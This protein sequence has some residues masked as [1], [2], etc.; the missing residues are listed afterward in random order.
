M[1]SLRNFPHQFSIIHLLCI[2]TV[3]GFFLSFNVFWYSPHPSVSLVP[4]LIHSIQPLL[5][6]SS[7]GLSLSSLLEFRGFLAQGRK[8]FSSITKTLITSVLNPP[9]PPFSSS[10][11]LPSSWTLPAHEQPFSSYPTL[12]LLPQLL[13]SSFLPPPHPGIISLVWQLLSWKTAVMASA[14]HTAGCKWKKVEGW[15][16]G[17]QG[18]SIWKTWAPLSAPYPT[19]STV[20]EACSSSTNTGLVVVGVGCA[21]WLPGCGGWGCWWGCGGGGWRFKQM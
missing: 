11:P 9:L 10:A 1:I 18:S 13:Q 8:T 5:H 2:L 16:W 7:Q 3:L 20:S 17:G 21:E 15:G 6:L 12:L 14:T 19:L 4:A